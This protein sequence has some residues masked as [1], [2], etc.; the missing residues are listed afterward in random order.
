MDSSKQNVDKDLVFDPR[1]LR[2][3]VGLIASLL[4]FVVIIINAKLTSSIPKSNRQ[5][6]RCESAEG[7]GQETGSTD[8][9]VGILLIRYA[10][11]QRASHEREALY[12]LP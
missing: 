2:L 9:R 1:A 7:K 3:T 10:H 11:K 5:T 6:H 12:I 8:E 4:P